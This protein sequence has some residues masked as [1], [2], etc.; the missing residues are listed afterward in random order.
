MIANHCLANGTKDDV[1]IVEGKD[2]RV[3]S[4]DGDDISGF[5]S[6]GRFVQLVMAKD[7]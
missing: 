2:E 6:S 7:V 4:M 3:L 5:K 1:E